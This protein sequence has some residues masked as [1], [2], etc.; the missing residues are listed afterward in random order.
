[1]DFFCFFLCP[2]GWGGGGGV[3]VLPGW[4]PD[5]T[6]IQWDMDNWGDGHIFI[7][8]F[9]IAKVNLTSLSSCGFQTLMLI[10]TIS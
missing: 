8:I 4:L 3:V 10:F 6:G 5:N 1:M 7:T 9:Y 2:C